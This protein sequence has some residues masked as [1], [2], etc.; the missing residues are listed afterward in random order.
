[1]LHIGDIHYKNLDK[2][3][4]L[5][6]I[7][8]SQ[9]PDVLNSVL[10][11]PDYQTVIADFMCEIEKSPAAILL[12]GDLSSYGNIEYY[13]KC[14]EFLKDR[15]PH[16]F[17]A[18]DGVQKLFIVPGN[19]DIDR[20]QISE[21]SLH[22]KFEPIQK[23]LREANFPEMP[24]NGAKFE[25]LHTEFKSLPSDTS[26]RILMININSCIGCGERRYYPD[27]IKKA[28]SELLDGN[29]VND[30]TKFI[31]DYDQIDTPAVDIQD[32]K[33]V[34]RRIESC[35]DQLLPIILT[36]HNLLP[37]K[38]PRVAMYTELLNSGYIRERLLMLNRPIIYLHGH[39]HDD[40][41]EVIQSPKY[42]E[43]K[44]I[45]ISAPLL[46]P[47][48]GDD[49]K[50]FGFNVIKIVVGKY[51]VPIGCKI[52]HRQIKSSNEKEERI[53]FWEPA[54]TSTLA[55]SY[56][57]NILRC[58]NECKKEE[59]YLADL[60]DYI[61]KKDGGNQSIEEI[62]ESIDQLSW[63][64]LLHYENRNGPLP[65]RSVKKVFS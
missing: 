52:T 65:M 9:F 32:L 28:L 29:E 13:K 15:I 14:L 54:K 19:H 18:S 40:P 37:Q 20:D 36:H 53:R 63:L 31:V 3:S 2:E 22:N 61:N 41:I 49:T 30:D 25:E 33:N 59:I 26:C 58:I 45:C 39:L 5:V 1:M 7:K 12:S 55:S 57:K 42:A 48:V 21:D 56:E 10:P 27:R 17:F 51:G 43:A 8:D 64:G 35:N 16:D 50:K 4:R 60:T 44:I 46:F 38:R 47:I 24:V 34:I 6:D 11:E 62:E 23:A